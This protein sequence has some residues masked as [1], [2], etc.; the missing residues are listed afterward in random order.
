MQSAAHCLGA[1]CLISGK[2][3]TEHRAQMTGTGRPH[4][5]RMQR[6]ET[7]SPSRFPPVSSAAA[8]AAGS[9]GPGARSGAAPGAT[10]GHRHNR[11]RTEGGPAHP[12]ASLS[13]RSAGKGFFPKSFTAK[14]L[15]H[16]HLHQT[17][18]HIS[19]PHPTARMWAKVGSQ[20][21]PGFM[22]AAAPKSLLLSVFKLKTFKKMR[23]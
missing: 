15:P 6:V 17:R 11:D 14:C 9:A 19:S 5:C 4:T 2:I 7:P 12:S 1:A 23:C 18:L 8:V 21:R 20:P 16:W 22:G 3:L 13:H 10:R